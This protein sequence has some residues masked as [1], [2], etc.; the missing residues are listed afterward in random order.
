MSGFSGD[1]NTGGGGDVYGGFDDGT[2]TQQQNPPPQQAY[3]QEQGYKSEAGKGGKSKWL[4]ILKNSFRAILIFTAL[5]L[6]AFGVLTFIYM[7][8]IPFRILTVFFSIYVVFVFFFCCL[9]YVL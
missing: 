3:S 2:G 7:T 6:V 4:N 1:A 5:G 9:F 8:W